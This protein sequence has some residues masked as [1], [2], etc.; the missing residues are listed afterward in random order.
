MEINVKLIINKIL[1]SKGFVVPKK[2]AAPKKFNHIFWSLSELE[3]DMINVLMHIIT[4]HDDVL[5]PEKV[6]EEL[7]LNRYI[8]TNM[9]DISSSLGYTELNI[10]TITSTLDSITKNIAT[11]YYDIDGGRQ[12]EK[13]TFLNKYTVTSSFNDVNKR[14]GIWVN[15][16]IIKI[17]REHTY[18]FK[19]FYKHAEFE[20]KSKYSKLMY[21]YFRAKGNESERFDILDF[22]KMMDYDLVTTEWDWSRLNQNILKRA[23]DEINKK[24]DMQI[25]YNK[26][27]S[28][29]KGRV[30]TTQVDITGYIRNTNSKELDYF[31]DQTIMNRK[32]FY[33]IEKE[34]KQKF[35]TMLRFQDRNAIAN[36]DA[37]MDKLRREAIK[38]RAEFEAQI[39][40]QEWSN[41]IKYSF[42]DHDGFVGLVGY[43]GRDFV[44]INNDY[45]MYDIQTSE[46]LST[47]ARDTYNKLT[48]YLV[49]DDGEGFGI[50]ET[51]S[52][53][54]TC[55]ISHTTG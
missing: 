3:T 35:A 4:K 24:T 42:T 46:E 23:R 34:V 39:L 16:D 43:D 37:Y 44:T 19:N 21:D 47:S 45:K 11:I 20:L 25:T 27:K 55:S 17:L 15:S 1:Y 7:E 50:D 9:H 22:A 51:T 6:G 40:L 54:K 28:M 52:Y 32:V 8:A 53:I 36:P 48:E 13:A 30:Q 10:Q 2:D 26:V 12:M 41:I 18:L 31:D 33:Y 14:I 49:S 29:D 38:N 5:N